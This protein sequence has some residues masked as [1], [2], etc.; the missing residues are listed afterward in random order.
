LHAIQ[1]VADVRRF[2][3][4]RRHPH[5]SRERLEPFL[6]DSSIRY[7]WLPALGGRRTPRKDSENA[8]WR[9]AAFRGYAD[10]METPEFLAAF[11]ELLRVAATERVVIMC[12]EALWWQ[13]HRRLIADALVARGHDVR[14]IQTAVSAPPHKLLS[15]A[16]L[17]AGRLTYAADQADL[18]L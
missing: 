1:L 3:A 2:P 14:H 18:S 5:F 10:Y 11:D 15:P 6:A 4:S 13:C 9:Q 17:E 16:R 12:A 8:G 7:L